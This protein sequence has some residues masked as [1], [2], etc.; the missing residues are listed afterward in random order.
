MPLE[1]ERKFLVRDD[2]WR[3]AADPGT[4][5]VQGYLCAERARTVRVRTAAG[6]AWLT[7]KGPATGAVRQEFEYEL[8]AH[9]APALL[10]LCGPLL[11]EKIRYRVPHAGL[12]W[13]VDVF[14]GGNRPL[15]LAEIELPAADAAVALPDWAGREVTGDHRY[16]NASLARRPYGAW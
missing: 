4:A 1:I 7:I 2:R 8:P 10:A 13:E 12:V 9:D 11:V 6:R 3:A 16:H 14:A 5:I 15:V